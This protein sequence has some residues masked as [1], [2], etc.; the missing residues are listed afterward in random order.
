MEAR[1][2]TCPLVVHAQ[3][4]RRLASAARGCS[5]S[6]GGVALVASGSIINT[7]SGWIIWM[8]NLSGMIWTCRLL[9]CQEMT[10]QDLAER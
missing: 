9:F 2:A 7:A 10:A 3:G 8:V 1:L 5:A 4:W 6:G